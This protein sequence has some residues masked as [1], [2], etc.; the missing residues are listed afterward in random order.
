MDRP[1]IA[2]GAAGTPAAI[3]PV[4]G[5]EPAPISLHINGSI[6]TL[7]LAPHITLAQVLRD[8]LGLT[9]TKIGCDRGTCSACTV[10]LDG[11]PV[12]SCMILAVDIAGR[13]ITT[14]EG[15]ADGG[16]LHRVQAAFIE[17]DA[18]QCGFCTPGMAMSCAA[19]V[20]HNSHPSPDDVR[21]AISGHLCRCGTYQKVVE[22]TLAAA[23][24]RKV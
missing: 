11:N 5:P 19:L 21:A 14:I 22:A 23:E 3:L 4:V 13:S 12:A 18:M 9:G 16:T 20:E 2:A 7:A 24:E 6:E 10:W 17:H 15:L 8:L 1:S